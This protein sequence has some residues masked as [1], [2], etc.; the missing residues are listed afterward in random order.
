MSSWSRSVVLSLYIRDHYHPSAFP[1]V[2]SWMDCM[3]RSGRQ[4]QMPTSMHLSDPERD[5]TH[6]TTPHHTPSVARYTT[7]TPTSLRVCRDVGTA[8]IV[9]ISSSVYGSDGLYCIL[10]SIVL[11]HRIF[12]I[13]MVLPACCCLLAACRPYCWCSIR[14]SCVRSR[15]VSHCSII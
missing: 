3:G 10:Y 5:A 8:G 12:E 2:S 7:T 15:F 9:P 13:S 4:G 14:L 11:S 6:H 1:P